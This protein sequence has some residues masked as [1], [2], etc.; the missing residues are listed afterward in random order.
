MSFP[1]CKYNQLPVLLKALQWLSIVL[2]IKTLF[3]K[4]TYKEPSALQSQIS[5]GH[6]LASENHLYFSYLNSLSKP[7]ALPPQRWIL[8]QE[9]NWLVDI[10]VCLISYASSFRSSHNCH[11]SKEVSPTLDK[12]TLPTLSSHSGMWFP[13][14]R[15]THNWISIHISMPVWFLS[16]SLPDCTF[17]ENQDGISCHII[18]ISLSTASKKYLLSERMNNQRNG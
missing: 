5:P 17:H 6:S 4:S 1:K 14:A 11:F 7:C 2:G 10:C 13:T 15:F 12:I 8:F 18:G 16:V 3:L 9:E